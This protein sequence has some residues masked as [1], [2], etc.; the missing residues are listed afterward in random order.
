MVIG[1][2]MKGV[3]DRDAL[4]YVAGYAPPNDVGLHDFRHADRG[5]MLASRARTASS[6]S[7]PS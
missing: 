3:R 7:A 6:R 5:S 4:D 1:R 2:R